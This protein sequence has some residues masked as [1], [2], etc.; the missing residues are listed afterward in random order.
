MTIDSGW[1]Q[2][3]KRECPAAFQS[4]LSTRPTT[5]FIDGQIKL[6]K[7]EWVNTWELFVQR[8]FFDT[9]DRAFEHNASVVVLGFDDYTHVPLCKSMT[10]RARNVKQAVFTFN[11]NMTLPPK[12]PDDWASCMRNRYFKSLVVAMLVR[13]V[14][15]RYEAHEKTVIID[16]MGPPIVLGRAL[17]RDGRVLPPAVLDPD[18]RRGECDIKALAWSTFGALVV[19]STDGDF[20]PLALLL[21]EAHA[22]RHVFLERIET[23][24]STT[25]KR[26]A[27]GATKRRM[28]FVCMRQ[29]CTHVQRAMKQH[30]E[31]CRAFAVLIALTGCDFSQSMPAIG[32]AKMWT[33]HSL[34]HK[35][36]LA[37]EHGILSA[38]T[39]SYQL[40]FSKS[41]RT[42]PYAQ[43]RD[44]TDID[45]SKAAYESVADAIVKNTAIAQ[46]TKNAMWSAKDATRHARNVMWTLEYWSTLERWPDP[47][48]V[49]FGFAV[50]AAGHCSFL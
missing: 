22:D 35:L 6:M 30:A 21:C 7:G 36:D 2:H 26:S 9:I 13:N 27:F 20:V 42:I 37:S 16:W 3:L 38:I 23:K 4:T 39:L 8:Q 47:M 48:Q 10:Q 5:W 45:A 46:K 43:I 33:A 49:K 12:P 28:E 11:E 50:D 32:P 19:Q 1:V 14:Q 15:R 18:A 31:P 34:M 44:T 29:L 17:D 24:I 25:G 40:N 41:I